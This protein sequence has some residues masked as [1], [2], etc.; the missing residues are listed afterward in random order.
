MMYYNYNKLISYHRFFNVLFGGRGIGKT[1]GAKSLLIKE[2]IKKG[3]QFV[4]LRRYGTELK[5]A[6]SGFFNKVQK[7][8]TDIK[9]N[10]KGNDCYINDKLAGCFCALSKSS[11]NKGNDKLNNVKYIIFDEYCI[12]N[13]TGFQRYLPN[14]M[15]ALFDIIET[16]GRTNDIQVI[17]LSNTVTFSNPLFLF[18]DITQN[19]FNNGIFKNDLMYVELCKTSKEL[20]ELKEST[21][22]M[23]LVKRYDTT[24]FEYNVNN[25]SLTDND[26]LITDLT[27]DYIQYY[28]FLTTENGKQKEYFVYKKKDKNRKSLIISEKG[29]NNISIKLT[30]DINIANENIL[31]FDNN[32][33]FFKELLNR[34]KS[35]NLF[36]ENI[37]IKNHFLNK[38]KRYI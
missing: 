11:N 15:Q 27:S 36:F 23:K 21:N 38:L 16:F 22:L 37:K 8:F 10:V 25:K 30:D 26:S 17:L 2:N 18:F 34:L 3:Y 12:D 32:S 19:S 35:G 29:N 20:I 1:Y 31:F 24:Y 7:D 6:K 9:L 28:M 4:W 14:E 5:T 13:R 33:L